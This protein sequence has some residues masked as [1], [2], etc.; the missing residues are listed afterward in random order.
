LKQKPK[1][2]GEQAQSRPPYMG[3]LLQAV[4]WGVALCVLTGIC[5][6]QRLH[7]QE[8]AQAGA[9]LREFTVSASALPITAAAAS[10]HVTILTRRDLEALGHGSVADILAREAGVVVDRSA[11]S[12]G[13]GS[14]YLRGADPSHVVVLVDYVRQNDPLSSRGSAVDLNTLSTGDVERIE[15]VRGNVSVVHA[16]ALAGLIHIFTRR[17]AGTGHAGVAAGGG[18]RA[19][20]A[21]FA[22]EHLRGS[23]SH[24]EDGSGAKGFSR[25]QSAN[26]GW[27]QVLDRGGS[28]VLAGR[29]AQSANQ[30]FPD[31]SGGN[32]LAVLR[33]LDSRS[34][35]NAQLSARAAINTKTMGRL[36]LQATAL[37]RRADESTAGVAPGLRDSYGLPAMA[38]QTDYRRHEVQALWL[39]RADS[40]LQFTWGMHHQRERGRLASVIEF[41]VFSLPA[42]FTLSR[43]VT[44]LMAEARYQWHEW[45]F[46]AGLRHERPGNAEAATHPMVSV[47]HALGDSLGHWGAST[48]SATKLPSFYSLAHPLVGNAS[49]RTERATH[50]ELYYATPG[51]SSWPSR[52]TLFSARYKDL[53]DFESGPPPRLVNRARINADGVEWRTGHTLDN[54]WQVRLDGSLMRVRDPSGMAVLRH[55]PRAQW[56]A[57]LQVPWGIRSDVTLLARHTGRRLDSSIPT[58]DQWL[59]PVTTVDVSARMPLAAALAT[60]GIENLANSRRAESIGTPVPGRRLRLALDWTLP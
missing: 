7:A 37:S 32:Q 51:R 33:E 21:G 22:G 19:A 1:R 8:H 54:G 28:L 59:T 42:D 9:A 46:Q 11:R 35:R 41:G 15:V 48:S 12:G 55:R 16:E 20:Q 25:A 6:P 10:Q 56:S 38:T 47:Q 18:L 43:S 5:A 26:A 57:H 39:A 17:A 2:E 44:S 58:G 52:I 3:S 13:Y 34:A 29:L 49:L 27:E 24:R 45:I 53:I 31:D 36:E 40:D 23:V 30:S 14:L 50:R 4:P 60:L